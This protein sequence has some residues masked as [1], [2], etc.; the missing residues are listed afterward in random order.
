MSM[1][2]APQWA[3]PIKPSG[4][5]LTTPTSEFPATTTSMNKA[6]RP[7]AV[8][9][10]S[11]TIAPS[12]N[13]SFP[14]LSQGGTTPTSLTGNTPAQPVLSYSR[15]T[16][17]PVTPTFPRDG[18]YFP[19]GDPAGQNGTHPHPFRY[20]KESIL[21]LWNEEKVRERPIELADMGIG[22]DVLVSK[23]LVKPVGL[24]DLSDIEKKLLATSVHPPN[25]TRRAPG[26][27]PSANGT[28]SRRPI[29]PP[30]TREAGP[31][32]RSGP[33]GGFGRGE[34]PAFGGSLGKPGTI[35][36]GAP[37][38]PGEGKTLGA[39]GGGFA[40][41]KRPGRRTDSVDAGQGTAWRP[42]RTVSGSFEGVLGFGTAG[43]STQSTAAT[44]NSASPATPTTTAGFEAAPGASNKEPEPNFGTGG[45]PGWGT[46]Q[47]KWRIA[48]GLNAPE[49]QKELHIPIL[50]ET[51]SE[52]VAATAPGTPLRER[53][54]TV[55]DTA[56]PQPVSQDLPTTDMIPTRPPAKQ[57]LGAVEWY[58]RDPGGQEQ[59]P[60]TGTQMHDWYSHSYFTDDL[61]LRRASE[62]SFHTLAELKTSTGNAVQPFLSPVRPRNLPPNLPLPFGIS[63]TVSPQPTNGISDQ[64]R[65]L[66]LSS[67]SHL[68]PAPQT[69]YQQ[70]LPE[71]NVAPGHPVHQ[72]VYEPQIP[73]SYGQAP[74]NA[75]G[76]PAPINRVN[77]F[78]SVGMASPVGHGPGAFPHHHQPVPP[79]PASQYPQFFSPSAGVGAVPQ[80]TWNVPQQQ[81]H[82]QHHQQ[83][84][85]DKR[86][87]LPAS[88]A[89]QQLQ[90][91]PIQMQEDYQSVIAVP[92]QEEEPKSLPEPTV[93]DVEPESV[94]S[95]QPEAVEES[96]VEETEPEPELESQ[97]KPDVLPAV[98]KTPSRK[99]TVEQTSRKSSISAAGA[100]PTSSTSS[101][102]PPAPASLPA[103][104]IAISTIAA[105]PSPDKATPSAVSA[106]P[107]P[108]ADKEG[109]RTGGLS[110]REIQEAEAKEAEAR[111]AAKAAAATASP[112]PTPSADEKITSMTWGLP[113][114]QKGAAP[115]VS[116]P[117]PVAGAAPAWGGG[118]AGPKKTLK[119]IQEEEE[120]RKAKLAQGQ[121]RTAAS[122]ANGSSA[123]S[124]KRGYADLAA[125]SQTG[126]STG[127]GWTTVGPGGKSSAGVAAAPTATAAAAPR[128]ASIPPKPVTSI[129]SKPVSVIT[130]T[131][132]PKA[133]G[134]A[135]DEGPSVEFIKWTKQAL[136]G[137]KINV[138]E[139]IQMLLSFPVDP[140]ASSR[141]D[142]LEIISDSVYANSSTLDGRRF[143]EEF[144]TRRK[145][146]ANR[147]QGSNG[148]AN[149]AK[150]V[151][152][153]GSLADVVKSVPKKAEDAGFRIVKA[154]G[155]KK[156]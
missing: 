72:G 43:T 48:A 152:G 97:A 51:R 83:Q 11:T 65:N 93:P 107:A 22:G 81:E 17:T 85:F 136:T 154:K 110:L 55:E 80:N 131:A 18:S 29:G 37:G 34:G 92:P 109:S 141:G 63:P 149:P 28:P 30:T 78:G 99:A 64:L 27:E 135:A 140:P 31:G 117:P 86:Q 112:I 24:R 87:G 60:F 155:K 120:K 88:G 156:N 41:V 104:P 115:S 52:S 137:L 105:Q 82:P 67:S 57:D 118:D 127:P 122:A 76:Q 148:T 13:V 143:A 59:G 139:F 66:N 70:Y 128:P 42:T 19:S 150:S 79:Q 138:D 45:G 26:A 36:G 108:W 5:A 142:V 56:T 94:D 106:R 58:Y 71:R 35:G 101:R 54:A 124:V 7:A 23:S 134:S 20:S 6:N 62:D 102:L 130:S 50:S 113:T 153:P 40:G 146:D 12:S 145:A 91:A 44:S 123:P 14:A 116:T 69:S 96:Q 144:M 39:I 151:S 3:K 25:P 132:K 73:L 84:Q 119:Q 125:A 147:F 33:M 98:A 126:Q 89:W 111:R 90:A 8:Q 133:N 32:S 46:G 100:T 68:D 75:W 95:I 61:P 74:V 9:S 103:K 77:S 114:S 129:P 10:P 15:A 4:N 21:S 49:S 121:G 1:H 47:K 2:F 53:D 16:H 38:A